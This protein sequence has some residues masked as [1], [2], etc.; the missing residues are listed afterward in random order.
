[1]LVLRC[2]LQVSFGQVMMLVGGH[3]EL[4]NWKP[5]NGCKMTWN[6]GDVW[7]AEVNLPSDAQLDFKVTPLLS[8]GSTH[9]FLTPNRVL[10]AVCQSRHKLRLGRR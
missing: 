2:S 7:T 8:K 1:M 10:P 4:G 3:K 9:T 5:E 6:D